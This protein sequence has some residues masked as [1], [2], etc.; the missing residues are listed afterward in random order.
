MCGNHSADGSPID[1]HHHDDR[2]IF[3]PLARTPRR[4]RRRAFLGD[5]GKGT[6]AFAVLTPAVVA[7]ACSSDSDE[8]ATT[9]TT[10][11]TDAPTTTQ[12]ADDP[13]ALRW[14]RTDRKSVV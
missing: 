11:T 14:A 13:N 10:S 6:V 8:T 3:M 9:S 2:P 5:I 4:M 7:A 1:H 12:A